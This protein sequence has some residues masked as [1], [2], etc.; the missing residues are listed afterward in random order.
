VRD[1]ADRWWLLSVYDDGWCTAPVA[2]PTAADTRRR[3]R[4]FLAST[5]AVVG[6]FA[7]AVGVGFLLPGVTWL[8]WVLLAASLAALT[9]AG[10]GA[11]RR[12]A[13]RRPVF[14]SSAEHAGA[15]AGATRVAL[16][17]VRAVAV[18]REGHEEVVTVALRRGKPIVYRSPD[19]TLGRLFAPWSPVPP[20]R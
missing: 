17:S 16:G 10:L 13:R 12:R 9:A 7:A 18:Q 8:P 6:L 11:A 1:G 20:T 4:A 15:D 3:L 2:V 5:C 19:R 14:G